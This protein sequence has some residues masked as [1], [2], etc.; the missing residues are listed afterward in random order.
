MASVDR[1]EL[2]SVGD[3]GD[4]SGS[5]ESEWRS[6]SNDLECEQARK[7]THLLVPDEVVTS[8]DSANLLGLGDDL[9]RDMSRFR[10]CTQGTDPDQGTHSVHAV[11]GVYIGGRVDG[12]PLALVLGGQGSSELV[13]QNLNIRS[14]GLTTVQVEAVGSGTKVSTSLLSET[15]KAGRLL[16]LV[17]SGDSQGSEDRKE[18]S[19]SEHCGV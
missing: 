16:A 14:S 12:L 4:V 2:I 19:V 11:K 10:F 3:A 18:D 17:R 7:K 5:L 15:V 1:L 9:S 8:D 13:V 6:E